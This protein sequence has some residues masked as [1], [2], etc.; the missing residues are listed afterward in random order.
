MVSSGSPGG[1]DLLAPDA[2]RRRIAAL[3]A[4]SAW[5]AAYAGGDAAKRAEMTRLHR[6]AYPG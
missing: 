6:M 4:D 5:S 2:A 1:P 3:R